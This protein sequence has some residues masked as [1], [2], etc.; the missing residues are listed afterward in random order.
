MSDFWSACALCLKLHKDGTRYIAGGRIV[1]FDCYMQNHP[2]EARLVIEGQA[3]VSVILG[4][5]NWLT[6]HYGDNTHDERKAS[7]AEGFLATELSKKDA[8]LRRLISH[9]REF[10]PE[11][12]DELIESRTLTA[13]GPD[14]VK[15]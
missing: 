6:I 8:A 11:A 10:G 13:L 9:W 7:Y 1:C 3:I 14:R 15:P 2:K 5:N 12:F 4:A